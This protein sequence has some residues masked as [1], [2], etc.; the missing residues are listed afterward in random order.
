MGSGWLR[1]WEEK[2][3]DIG[4]D[5]DEDYDY[6]EEDDDNKEIVRMKVMIRKVIVRPWRKMMNLF[7][8]ANKSCLSSWFTRIKKSFG[9]KPIWNIL[10][11]AFQIVFRPAMIRKL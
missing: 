2:D 7:K 9:V 3:D 1:I 5:N 4:E 8:V 10:Q 11:S 6:E